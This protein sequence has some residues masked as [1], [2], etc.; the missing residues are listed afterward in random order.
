MTTQ[1][2]ANINM[3]EFISRV[4]DVAGSDLAVKLLQSQLNSLR[5]M[6]DMAL[7]Q[8]DTMGVDH[9]EKT[10]GHSARR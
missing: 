8:T 9:G 1:L 10:H 3:R 4:I 2:P 7:A 5:S 6:I